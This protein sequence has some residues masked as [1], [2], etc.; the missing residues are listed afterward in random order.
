MQKKK[1]ILHFIV[2]LERGG[3]ETMLVAVLKE[4]TEY[5]NIVVTL[6]EKNDFKKEFFCD[7]FICLNQPAFRRFP[8]AT[9]SF[10][11]LIKKYKPNIV[12]SHLVLPSFIARLG[13]PKNIPLISTIHSS[14]SLTPDYKKWFMK[15][16][17][18]FTYNFKRSVIITVSKT[19]LLDYFNFLKIK[20]GQHYVINSFAKENNF[21][22]SILKKKRQGSL[23]IIAVG[24]LRAVKNY[25]YFI[26]AFKKMNVK[27]IELDIYGDGPQKE[28]L[29]RAIRESGANINL[30]GKV[31]NISQILPNYDLF[32][33]ASKYEGFSVSVLE[34]M[35]A[36]LPLLLSDIPSFREQCKDTAT[37]FK[38]NEPDNFIQKLQNICNNDELLKQM[39]EKGKKRMINNYTVSNH[40]QK[41]RR[42]Y[43]CVL[44]SS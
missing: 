42:V 37:Y 27:N 41:L 25:F 30:K 29:Q 12:H 7:E 32:V 33:M 24:S 31:E 11:S 22:T 3:A 34:A 4:L 19:V 23:K 38:L 5:K 15:Y 35:A 36:G 20:P 16:L 17:D 40:L 1:T 28:E 18:K 21:S 43:N 9:L 6:S 2:S 39:S 14:I 13:T 8:L 26:E 10:R 44:E